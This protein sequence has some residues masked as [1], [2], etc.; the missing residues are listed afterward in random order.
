[1]GGC[2]VRPMRGGVVRLMRFSSMR[3]MMG[4][5]FVSLGK[6]CEG[7]QRGTEDCGSNHLSEEQFGGRGPSL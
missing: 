1:M 5:R 2:C 7:T 4:D 3:A 6:H